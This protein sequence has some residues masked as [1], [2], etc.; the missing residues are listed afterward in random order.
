MSLSFKM[1]LLVVSCLLL[2]VTRVAA[3]GC[4]RWNTSL[5]FPAAALTDVVA[6]IAAGADLN[7]RG[8]YG[9]DPPALRGRVQ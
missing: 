6:C 1:R 5:F 4:A 2:L 3:A 7:A 9:H 8:E